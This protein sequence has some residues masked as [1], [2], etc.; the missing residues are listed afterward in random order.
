MSIDLDQADADT[1]YIPFVSPAACCL[2]NTLSPTATST[3]S[4]V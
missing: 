3:P 2:T 4:I 1:T